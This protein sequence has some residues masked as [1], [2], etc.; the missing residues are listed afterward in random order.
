VRQSS[1]GLP[2]VKAIG[3]ALADRGIV[4][5]SMNLTDF[6]T[7]SIAEAFDAVESEARARGTFVTG[8]EL[9]GLAPAAALTPAVAAHVR[10]RDFDENR[11]V[12]ERRLEAARPS[13]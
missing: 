3:I 4:Q 12:L 8:S 11:M 13:R 7:T 1:G 10:L 9:I 2:A 5:V 6:R